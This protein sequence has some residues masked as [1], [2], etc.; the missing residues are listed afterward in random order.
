M[1]PLEPLLKDAILSRR[2]IIATYGGLR[3]EMCP[4]IIGTK[5]DKP[6]CLF[7]QY[8]GESSHGLEPPGSPNNWRCLPLEGLNDVEVNEGDWYSGSN[9]TTVQS[10]IDTIDTMTVMDIGESG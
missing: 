9:Y 3:R 1:H 5:D 8:A 7:Y 10:C 2:R 6:H 4:H